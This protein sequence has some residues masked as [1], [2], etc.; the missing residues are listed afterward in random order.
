[1]LFIHTRWNETKRTTWS[2]ILLKSHFT[3]LVASSILSGSVRAGNLTR[4]LGMSSCLYST[5]NWETTQC[6]FICNSLR[7]SSGAGFGPVRV[8]RRRRR[9]RGDQCASDQI[10]LL[11]HSSHTRLWSAHSRFHR[12]MEKKR[13]GRL[14]VIMMMVV[15]RLLL[16]VIESPIYSSRLSVL[17]SVR[18]RS[19]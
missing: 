6:H 3:S 8:T 4:S 2:I 13:S 15:E 11:I 10:S 1:M 7:E 19:G 5:D 18:S 9:K 14:I 12:M 17:S 16:M